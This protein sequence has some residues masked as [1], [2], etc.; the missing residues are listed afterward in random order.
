MLP[1]VAPPRRHLAP[2]CSVIRP[3]PST[4]PHGAVCCFAMPYRAHGAASPPSCSTSSHHVPRHSLSNTAAL[5][6]APLQ[7]LVSCGVAL[8]PH[9]AVTRCGSPR[10]PR[11][12]ATGPSG[13][14]LVTRGRMPSCCNHG[15]VRASASPPHVSSSLSCV[16]VPES[17]TSTTPPRMPML[18]KRAPAAPVPGRDPAPPS[19]AHAAPT[20]P[21]VIL[22]RPVCPRL[23]SPAVLRRSSTSLTLCRPRSRP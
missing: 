13:C 15:A 6:A 9:I 1:L 4:R 18:L 17:H 21:P 12:A 11:T 7:I 5:F 2:G 10:H 8:S 20:A 14:P 3:T 22:I 16:V 23:P 19:P